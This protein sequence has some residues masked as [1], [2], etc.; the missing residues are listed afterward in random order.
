VA[1]E[2]G[3][4]NTKVLILLQGKRVKVWQDGKVAKSAPKA[5]KGTGKNFS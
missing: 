5:G 2:G 3:G 4:G 1:Y